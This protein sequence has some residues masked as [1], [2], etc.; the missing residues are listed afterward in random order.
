MSELGYVEGANVAFEPR[1]A[2]GRFRD[3]SGLSDE[4]LRLRVDVI[5]TASTEASIAASRAT[6]QIPIVTTTGG[7]HV[8]HGLAMSL[9]QPGRNVTGMTSIA[10]QLTGKRLELLREVH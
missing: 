6:D 5:V 7:D 4:L 10:S 9:A 8:S 3:L 2:R 1:F